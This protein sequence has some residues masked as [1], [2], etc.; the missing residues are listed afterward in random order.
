MRKKLAENLALPQGVV[1]G[2][3]ERQRWFT[4]KE[5]NAQRHAPGL[6]RRTLAPQRPVGRARHMTVEL[7]RD[8]KGRWQ[9][10]RFPIIR[11]RPAVKK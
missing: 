3:D 8:R 1:E 5:I 11:N 2:V 7:Y 4:L 9:S 10:E 6:R